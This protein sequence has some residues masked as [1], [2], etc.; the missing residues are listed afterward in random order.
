MGRGPSASTPIS[1]GF[2]CATAGVAAA[3][4]NNEI[5]A[6][7]RDQSRPKSRARNC[8]VP[9]SHPVACNIVASI[10]PGRTQTR[11]LAEVVACWGP[12]RPAAACKHFINWVHR[13]LHRST[14]HVR[15]MRHS[16]I[17]FR[18]PRLTLSRRFYAAGDERSL[19][20]EARIVNQSKVPPSSAKGAPA[21]SK[22]LRTESLNAPARCCA[23]YRD[24]STGRGEKNPRMAGLSWPDAIAFLVFVAWL[25]ALPAA[26]P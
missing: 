4:N 24:Q 10:H 3:N 9:A 23:R 8:Q 11:R 25:Y 20:T 15:V 14:Y 17:W 7:L 26:D 21:M 22:C 5:V 6:V 2:S 13:T 12:Q 18:H 16:A 19:S 1:S